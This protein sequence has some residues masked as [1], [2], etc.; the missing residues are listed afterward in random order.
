M[1]D[2]HLELGLFLLDICFVLF[3]GVGGA[4][5]FP[6]TILHSWTDLICICIHNLSHV[7]V[8]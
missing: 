5:S 7:K 3:C 4:S 6:E 1:F 2:K 8:G